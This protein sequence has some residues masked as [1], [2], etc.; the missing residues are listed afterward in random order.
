MAETRS[1]LDEAHPCL[2]ADCG[3]PWRVTEQAIYVADVA[4][5]VKW[6]PVRG[7]CSRGY[8]AHDLDEYNEALAERQRRGWSQV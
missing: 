4:G 3:A 2:V 8:R 1:R 6:A 5:P 7:E